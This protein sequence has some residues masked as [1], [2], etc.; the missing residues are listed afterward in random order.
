[1][2]AGARG[3]KKGL[4]SGKKRKCDTLKMCKSHNGRS[5]TKFSPATLLMRRELYNWLLLMGLS[6]E[7]ER[8]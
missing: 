3:S 1:M 2:Q 8:C 6:E 4:K 7:K 5:P